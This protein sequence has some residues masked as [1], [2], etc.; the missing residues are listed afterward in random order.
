MLRAITSNREEKRSEPRALNDSAFTV[1]FSLA[2]I[3]YAFQ[4]KLLDTSPKGLSILVNK[5]SR[6]LEKLEVGDVLN[7]RV[8]KPST[9]RAMPHG[10]LQTETRHITERPNG[11]FVVGFSVV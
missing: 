9:R 7:M 11:N 3:A 6:L 10:Y 4:F 8:Y 2:G 1:E 5:K